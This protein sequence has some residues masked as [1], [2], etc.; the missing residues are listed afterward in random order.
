MARNKHK[1]KC[2]GGRT[3]LGTHLLSDQ[4]VEQS[5]HAH[6]QHLHALLL[7]QTPQHLQSPQLQELLLGIGE[8]SQ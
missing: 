3:G 6:S 1:A 7:D 5:D 4:V 2:T 8:V